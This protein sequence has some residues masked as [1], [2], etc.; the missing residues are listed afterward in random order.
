MF[1]VVEL[2][3]YRG[4]ELEPWGSGER[5]HRKTSARLDAGSCGTKSNMSSDGKLY[6]KKLNMK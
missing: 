2:Y 5:S 4:I 1:E 3:R 6:F